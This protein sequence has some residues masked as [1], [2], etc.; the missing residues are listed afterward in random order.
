MQ[1]KIMIEVGGHLVSEELSKE[2]FICN[3]DKCK[4][5]CC[6]EG[7]S[8]APL[9]EDE[10]QILDE[11]YP[12][13]K[14]LMTQKGIEAIEAQGTFVKDLDGDYTTT[15]VDGNKE[16]AY[17]TWENGITK[18]AIEKAYEQGIVDWKKPI[19]CHL[20]PIRLTQYP[21]FDMLHYDRWSICSPACSFGDEHKVKVYQFLKEPLIRKYG[22]EWYQELDEIVNALNKS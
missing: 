12:K 14:H 4:G 16:C 20:Y 15:C 5:A 18:C 1:E 9:N 22:E 7:D 8:G 3:L 10:L 21:D 11:I 13:V 2:N 19:S 6:I 17:V